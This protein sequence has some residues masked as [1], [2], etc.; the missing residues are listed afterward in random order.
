MLLS[1]AMRAGRRLRLRDAWVRVERWL[2]R[3]RRGGKRG[4]ARCRAPAVW[5]VGVYWAR[6]GRQDS[7]PGRVPDMYIVTGMSKWFLLCSSRR[8]A[9]TPPGPHSAAVYI[10][11]PGGSPTRGNCFLPCMAWHACWDFVGAA[12]PWR[13]PRELARPAPRAPEMQ[14]RPSVD[15]F[16]AH[17]PRRRAPAQ[18][19]P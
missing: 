8:S 10:H 1:R 2:E 15:R 12:P 4:A 6:V 18:A 16:A 5:W 17:T 19:A 14:A 9:R 7:R 3:G 13:P 11:M